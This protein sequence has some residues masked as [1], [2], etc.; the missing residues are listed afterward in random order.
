MS[1]PKGRAATVGLG[2][3]CSHNIEHNRHE[4]ASSIMRE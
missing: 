2:G 3:L 1:R 4:E